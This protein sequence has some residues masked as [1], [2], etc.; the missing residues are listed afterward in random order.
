M[1]DFEL[2]VSVKSTV[3]DYN[4]RDVCLFFGYVD[5]AHFYYVHIGKVA[6]PHCNQ[7][8]IVNGAD[9]K[10]ISLTST[11]GTQWTDEWHRVKLTRNAAT[12]RIELFFDN[13]EKPA[14]TAEDKTFPA[15]RVGVGSFDDT[16]DWDDF[17]L[18]GVPAKLDAPDAQ[19]RTE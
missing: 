10:A 13:F 9:R 7:V 4:H 2:T 15:G 1:G 14:M 18:R 12:G 17:Q 5:P 3:D 8:F 6:D 19:P 11:E 16:A